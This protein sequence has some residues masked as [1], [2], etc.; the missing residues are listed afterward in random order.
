MRTCFVEVGQISSATYATPYWLRQAASVCSIHSRPRSAPKAVPIRPNSYMHRHLD[1][2]YMMP[3]Y[4][5][6]PNSRPKQPD[7][8][9]T[10]PQNTPQEIPQ[11]RTDGSCHV[12]DNPILPSN[13]LNTAQSRR[14]GSRHQEQHPRQSTN[15]S[16][17]LTSL[18]CFT[19]HLFIIFS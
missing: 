12:R 10:L 4:P 6:K 2:T 3:P 1:L 9:N 5:L 16:T 8:S 14:H 19:G 13:S 11:A 15:V 18:A 7:G 17:S